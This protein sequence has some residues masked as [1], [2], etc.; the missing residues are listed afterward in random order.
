MDRARGVLTIVLLAGSVWAGPARAEVP[1]GAPCIQKKTSAT[2][3][4]SG[5]DGAKPLNKPR[6][7]RPLPC[8]KDSAENL[9]KETR[10]APPPSRTADAGRM[11]EVIY[12][13]LLL[14]GFPVN[15]APLPLPLPLLLP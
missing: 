9:P 5:K 8:G 3:L 15:P 11:E 12:T 2:P 13:M 14:L 10:A 6:S 4:H 1:A 7:A